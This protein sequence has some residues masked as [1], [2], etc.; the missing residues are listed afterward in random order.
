[1]QTKAIR[2]EI[3]EIIAHLPE[4][5]PPHVLAY[6]RELSHLSPDQQSRFH[7]FRQIM[8]E[9]ANLLQRLAQ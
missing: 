2:Q 9:D 6:L 8:A 3:E 4:D 1:M 7:T 5:Q